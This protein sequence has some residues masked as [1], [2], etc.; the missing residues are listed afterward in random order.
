LGT[1][2]RERFSGKL[3]FPTSRAWYLVIVGYEEG[4]EKKGKGKR[5]EG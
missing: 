1:P 2:A 4:G 5:E 3:T